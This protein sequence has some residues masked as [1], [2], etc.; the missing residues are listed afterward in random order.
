VTRDYRFADAVRRHWDGGA[1][2]IVDGLGE[3][4][5]EENFAALA[6]CGHWISLG[7]ASG[8]LQP[9]SPD[10]LVHKSATFS[11]PVVFDYVA[12][13]AVLAERAQR[14]WAALADGS[15]KLPPIER[16][17]LDAASRA[18]ERIESRATVGALVLTA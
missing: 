3:A 2:L 10:W 11:R 16:W 15:V 1:E 8:P 17:S 5:R 4:A 12:T 14:L 7:Q 18:H 13:P 6:R 9:L